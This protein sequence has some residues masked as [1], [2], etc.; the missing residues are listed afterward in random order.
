METALQ[1]ET[2]LYKERNKDKVTKFNFL[3]YCPE[4]RDGHLLGYF[5]DIESN[6]FPLNCECGCLY[7]NVFNVD[8]EYL[9]KKM[10]HV[11]VV[12]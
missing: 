6:T 7:R 11:E 1:L 3:L 10:K 9:L 4:C 8:L 2:K 5:E 12:W